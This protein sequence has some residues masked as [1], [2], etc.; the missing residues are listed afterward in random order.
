MNS[1]PATF[2]DLGVQGC[3]YL[4]ALL[5]AQ[6]R[7]RPIVPTRRLAME[8][9]DTLRTQNVIALVPTPDTTEPFAKWSVTPLEG[10]RWR[11]GWDAY[12]E[13]RLLPALEEHLE[14]VA[15]D[16]PGQE[17][18]LA[19]WR[20]LAGGEAESFFRQ[21][22]SKHGFN[23]AWSQDLGYAR[24]HLGTEISTAQWRYV[25]WAAVRKG[26]SHILTQ[27]PN[28]DA[29]REVIY[30]EL[31]RRAAYVAS[32]QWGKCALPPYHPWPDSSLA[33]VFMR[34]LAD[35]DWAYW[36]QVPS[37]DN[38]RTAWRDQALAHSRSDGQSAVWPAHAFAGPS[39]SS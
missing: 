13:E 23:E 22:L 30:N 29:L 6:A 14:G 3:L 32:G 25:A 10:I 8:A 20:Q 24:S 12:E 34:H 26:A 15:R 18:R 9:L 33:A 1:A 19:L 35:L 36:S 38:L 27:M 28:P 11:L 4:A 31:N 2:E 5:G 17:I 39:M 37:M 7:R 21:Q 16:E